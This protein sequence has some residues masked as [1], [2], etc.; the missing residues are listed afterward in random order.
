MKDYTLQYAS[1]SWILGRI[2][3]CTIDSFVGSSADPAVQF[4]SDML[5]C[6]LAVARGQF[7]ST[8]TLDNL[9]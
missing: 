4:S 2:G 5:R 9:H 7:S 1:H 6:E 3:Q 8:G